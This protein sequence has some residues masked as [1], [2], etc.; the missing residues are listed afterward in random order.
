MLIDNHMHL[1]EIPPLGWHLSLESC[2]QR[3]EE[4]GI[5]CAG[6]MTITDWPEVNRGSLEQLAQVCLDSGGRF[7]PYARFH[8]WYLD[9]ILPELDRVFGELKFKGIKLHPVTTITHPAAEVS[10]RLMRAA[11][12]HGAPVLFHCGDEP[13]TTPLAVAAAARACPDTTVILGHMGGYFHVNEAIEVAERLDNIV[14]ETSA[15]PYPIAIADAVRRIGAG[16]VLFGSDG[17]ACSPRLELEKVR[18]AELEPVDEAL[19][20]G[21]NT[22]RLLEGVS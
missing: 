21:G 5:D 2:L 7:Y 6:I 15:M 8:P 20:L 19:V 9:E 22:A 12:E 1:D 17:P 4:A 14:L 3:M 16:R 11:G 18:L 10:I 13:M